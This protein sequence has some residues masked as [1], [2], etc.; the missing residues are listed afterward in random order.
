MYILE[1]NFE[2]DGYAFW[3]K[4][5][6]LLGST[7]GM[8]YDCRNV[9]NWR[10]LLAKTHVNE[11]TACNILNTLA[12][13]EAIDKELWYKSKIVWSQNLVDNVR[14]AFKRR[15]SEMPQKPLLHTETPPQ[16]DKCIQKPS[17]SDDSADKNGESKVKESK[18]KKSKEEN[19][20]VSE[21]ETLSLDDKALE[22]CKYYETLKPGQ[23]ISS[24][25]ATL[26]IFIDQYTFDWTKEAIQMSITKKGKF[27]KPW[28]ETVLKN[29]TKDGKADPEPP[30]QNGNKKDTFSAFTPRSDAVETY[31]NLEKLNQERMQDIKVN[32]DAL[33]GIGSKVKGG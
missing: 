28:I 20:N 12:D 32:E 14:D 1:S 13:L 21:T 25:L 15:I 7:D 19:N 6:E 29:W 24:E 18:V 11:Q 31:K 27:I 16:D 3:F 22:L 5:L 10:F 26:K 17:D 8:F 23:S 33:K 9:A 4:V 2:N 30:K